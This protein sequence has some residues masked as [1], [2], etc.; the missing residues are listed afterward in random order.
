MSEL[1]FEEMDQVAGGNI[2]VA[3]AVGWAVGKALDYLWDNKEEYWDYLV[4]CW[5]TYGAGPYYYNY[6]S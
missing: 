4:H 1:T 5:G 3:A 6:S 2:F